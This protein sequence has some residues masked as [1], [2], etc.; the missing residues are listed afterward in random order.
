MLRV[1]TKPS[2][3]LNVCNMNRQEGL[4]STLK[5]RI[6]DL[7]R[8]LPW[9]WPVHQLCACVFFCPPRGHEALSSAIQ[10]AFSSISFQ[11]PE[12]NLRQTDAL[13]SV[14]AS[15]NPPHGKVEAP[16]PQS[17]PQKLK[18]ASASQL[19]PTDPECRSDL[20]HPSL[21]PSHFDARAFYLALIKNEPEQY[22]AVIPP[23]LIS[24]SEFVP[25][26]NG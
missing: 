1:K 16:Q 13:T 23:P 22:K 20:L 4:D 10:V 3:I 6:L 25:K 21:I 17:Q 18:S 2:L 12:N 15:T 24:C 26:S 9:H 7:S 19:P 8:P 14:M 5:G 11:F